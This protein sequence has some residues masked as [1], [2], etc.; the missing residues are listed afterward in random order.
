MIFLLLQIIPGLF[1]SWDICAV[2]TEASR[3]AGNET[4]NVPTNS[5]Q[6][7]TINSALHNNIINIVD[8]RKIVY[9]AA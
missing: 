7:A 3:D 9:L 6:K 4:E 5:E 8:T 1:K 2:H